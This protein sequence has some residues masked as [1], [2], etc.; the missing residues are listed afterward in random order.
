MILT[1]AHLLDDHV[2]RDL[3]ENVRDEVDLVETLE[4]CCL[5]FSIV[6]VNKVDD[7]IKTAVV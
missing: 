5:G 3:K 6:A 4:T 7:R 1:R 2:T